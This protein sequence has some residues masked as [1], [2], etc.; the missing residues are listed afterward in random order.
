MNRIISPLE[1]GMRGL[2]LANLQDALQML[3]DRGG[4]GVSDEERR[5]FNERLRAERTE[6]LYGEMTRRLVALFQRQQGHPEPSGD[7]DEQ[8]AGAL[9][10][11]LE[12][13]GLLDE[14]TAPTARVVSGVVRR[15]DDVP[16]Q[17]VRVRAAHEADHGLGNSG[18]VRSSGANSR[19]TNA[20]RCRTN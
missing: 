5:G 20:S 4:L 2:Q 1:Q 3:L 13:W 9:N 15:E 11:L 8:T 14:A 19:D 16:L 7:V 6:S 18:S 12:E 17:G 10:A